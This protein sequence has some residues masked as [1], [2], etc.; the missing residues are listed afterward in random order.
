MKF[1]FSANIKYICYGVYISIYIHLILFLSILLDSFSKQGIIW[2]YKAQ[3][4]QYR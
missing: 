1:E 2:D 4:S 3:Y